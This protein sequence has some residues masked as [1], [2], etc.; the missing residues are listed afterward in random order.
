[1]PTLLTLNTKNA[2]RIEPGQTIKCIAFAFTKTL[3]ALSV[4]ACDDHRALLMSVAWCCVVRHLFDQTVLRV[5]IHG[6]M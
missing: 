5:D 3:P 4:S 2:L 1:M 6:S